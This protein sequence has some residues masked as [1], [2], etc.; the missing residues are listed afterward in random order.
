VQYIVSIPQPESHSYEV[1]LI[2]N[3]CEHDTV[4]LKLPN[5]M[6][7]YYQMMD[8]ADDLENLK[9]KDENG[10]DLPVKQLNNNSWSLRGV[11]D[12]SFQVSYSIRTK[13]KFVACSYVDKDHAYLVPGNSFLYM[14]ERID[15][16]VNVRV[17]L[18]PEWSKIATGLEPV[19]GKS[20]EFSAP[21]FDILY[22]CPILIGNLEELPSFEVNGIEHQ[23][24][25]YKMGSFDRELLM[26][27]LKGA[28]QASVDIIGDIPYEKYTFIGIGPG[29]GGI[30]HLNN[31]TVSFDGKQLNS[32]EGRDRMLSFLTHEYF[33]HYNVKRIRPFEL[34]PFDYDRGSR[35]NLL[36]IC[37]GLTVYYESR[38]LKKA[39]LIDAEIFLS[40]I[41]S[42][43]STLEK[44]SGRFHQSLSQASFNTWE[45]G[46]F[47]SSG[48]G[49]DKSISVYNKG[50]VLAML[51]DL[52]IRNAAEN[53]RSLDDVLRT[54]YWNFYKKEDRGFTD[55][56]FQ[57]VCEQVAGVSLN[58][59]FEYV[60][61]TKELDYSKY[62]AYAGLRIDRP[63]IDSHDETVQ[64]Q[65]RISRLEDPNNLQAAIL[66]SW[67][68]E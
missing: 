8:Y 54:L 3:E 1:E 10:N 37:E 6:P 39:G 64:P 63:V 29:R 53:T 5:W 36:W 25:G 33:H 18:N 62:L 16:P 15:K 13:R 19:P 51:L 40:D 68:G 45:E 24:I 58:E 30:E 44:D 34:G 23:F 11:G 9:V 32:P 22:D 41:S 67:L 60:Y 59:L 12:L 31:T 66:N 26:D 47:G 2:I 56:E 57:Q 42:Q 4:L 48:D 61:T 27:N 35:T 7:G 43:I 46:P 55:A 17:V 49:P 50:A 52:E 38:I 65:L 20:N 14:D 21:D 28:V